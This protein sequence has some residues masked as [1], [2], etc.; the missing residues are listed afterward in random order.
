M[1]VTDNILAT[2]RLRSA[3]NPIYS[4]ELEEAYK[5]PGQLIREVVRKARRDG[6]PIANKTAN[7]RDGYFLASTY[8]EFEPTLNDI[9]GRYNSLKETY[10]A[11]LKIYEPKL[12]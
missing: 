3:S 1:I 9:R 6:I 8:S 10:E 12:F 4:K 5:V 2:I 7:G 11:I